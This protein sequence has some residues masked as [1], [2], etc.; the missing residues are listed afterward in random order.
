MLNYSLC[1]I[2]PWDNLYDEWNWWNEICL[3]CKIIT[4]DFVKYENMIFTIYA[5]CDYGWAEHIEYSNNILVIWK[6]RTHKL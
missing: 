3:F 4:Q 5:C 2:E 6:M 1:V